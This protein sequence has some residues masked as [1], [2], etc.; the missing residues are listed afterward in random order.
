MTQSSEIEGYPRP[1]TP[2]AVQ[3]Q[4]GGEYL[5]NIDYL[6]AKLERKPGA[7]GYTAIE[8]EYIHSILPI[9][10]IL[11]TEYYG[12]PGTIP[13]G[14]RHAIWALCPLVADNKTEIC[15][16]KRMYQEKVGSQAELLEKFN[17]GI[18]GPHYQDP[19]YRKTLGDS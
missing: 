9:C 2:L 16:K 1:T 11:A 14:Q 12:G 5:L 17:Q 13:M 8:G 7:Q 3:H 15:P 6:M 10:L 18:D 4:C 19:F